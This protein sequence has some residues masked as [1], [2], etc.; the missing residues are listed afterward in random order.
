MAGEAFRASDFFGGLALALGLGLATIDFRERETCFFG[1]VRET[2]LAAFRAGAFA[3][4]LA[5]FRAGAFATLL[6]FTMCLGRAAFVFS[7]RRLAADFGDDCRVAERLIPFATGLLI[8]IPW[9]LNQHRFAQKT[10][11]QLNIALRPKST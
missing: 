5:A 4:L 7:G 3:T 8:W 2:D 10:S 9:V 11:A 1:E 6:A